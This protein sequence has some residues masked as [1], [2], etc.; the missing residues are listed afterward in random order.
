[1]GNR[2]A[3]KGGSSLDPVRWAEGTGVSLPD[4]EWWF[5]LPQTAEVSNEVIQLRCPSM[6]TVP[7][8]AAEKSGP[9]GYDL[10][11]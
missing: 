6:H 11:L 1:M 8:A 4:P 9:M 3:Y 10:P 2:V 5:L 7:S